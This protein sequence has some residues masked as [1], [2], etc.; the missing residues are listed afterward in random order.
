MTPGATRPACADRALLG[1]L[2]PDGPAPDLESPAPEVLEFVARTAC[3]HGVAGLVLE[4]AALVGWDWSPEAAAALERGRALAIRAG[5][6]A[7][8]AARDAV[9]ALRGAGCSPV[10]AIKGVHLLPVLYGGAGARSV[11]DADLLVRA[12]DRE[13]AHRALLASGHRFV[14]KPAGRPA[15]QRVAYERTYVHPSGVIVDVHTGLCQ[16]ARA[17]LDLEAWLDR[18]RAVPSLDAWIP[19]AAALSPED[20]LLA[21]AVRQAMD[22]FTGPLRQ[23]VDVAWWVARGGADLDLAARRARAEGVHTA[24]WASLWSAHRRLGAPASLDALEPAAPRPLR[25]LWIEAALGRPGLTPLPTDTPIRVAQ[26]LLLAPLL[27]DWT[28]RARFALSYGV[29]RARD[30]AVPLGLTRRP[31]VA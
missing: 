30:S 27:D 28:L 31:G 25:R 22:C 16:P 23:T 4:R 12:A 2:R 20:A 13:R 5:L 29:T 1:L 6:R 21:L 14:A 10:V 9:A 18:A 3:R 19:G 8:L 26:A 11:L 17:R 7:H 15:S 24:L